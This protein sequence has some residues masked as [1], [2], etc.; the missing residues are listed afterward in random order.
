VKNILFLFLLFLG[1]EV[2]LAQ[3]NI[4]DSIQN[5]IE[6]SERDTNLVKIL[7]KN[8]RPYQASYP[9]IALSIA[10]L[11]LEISQE[12]GWNIGIGR[13]NMLIGRTYRIMGEYANALEA[14]L[15]AEQVLDEKEA[16]NE[17]TEVWNNIGVIYRILM[18]YPKALSY[19]NKALKLSREI[20]NYAVE[21]Y[22]L[23]SLGDVYK[24]NQEFKEALNYY[25]EAL[26]VSTTQE[27]I[28]G[29]AP[30]TK[31]VG[32][33]YFE[34]KNYQEAE[35]YFLK[36][37]EIYEE[38]PSDLGVA[39]SLINLAQLKEATQEFDKGIEYAEQ[40]LKIT[41]EVGSKERIY[42]ALDILKTLYGNVNNYEKAYFYQNLFLQ[43][44]DSLLANDESLEI[45]RLE[46][47][48]EIYRQEQTN[49][50]LK[51]NNEISQQT[52]FLQWLAMASGL[53]LALIWGF[54]SWYIYKK[55]KKIKEQGEELSQKNEELET[56]LSEINLKN[57]KLID[58]LNY[59]QRMQRALLPAK[60]EI[61]QI[62][63]E[64]FVFFSPKDLVSGDFYWAGVAA[65]HPVFEEIPFQNSTQKV[66]KY[67]QGEKKVF[68]VID[69]TGHGV[70]GG[71]MSMIAN[72]LLNQIVLEKGITAPDL[73]LREIHTKLK[74]LNRKSNDSEMKEGM[75]L[76]I[77]TIDTEEKKVELSAAF[78]QMIYFKN[79]E[80][81]HL[82]GNKIA[83]GNFE[84]EQFFTKT[85]IEIDEPITL[86]LFT[87]GY[88]D[89]FG[90]KRNRKFSPKRMRTLFQNIYQKPMEEQYY[91]IKAAFE[92]WKKTEEQTDDVLVTGL[93][94]TPYK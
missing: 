84:L 93:K 69:C 4:P 79:D 27:N 77:C 18:D 73:V 59:A 35:K 5:K 30:S 19:H 45:G 51:K 71:L 83:I 23:N 76:S 40:A 21:A 78:S 91:L 67:F 33:A 63:T 8:V 2:L 6:A 44:K 13:A 10:E 20:K 16:P 43:Y 81:V 25:Q 26:K 24:A 68:S 66:L 28:S 64:H 94:I 12:K 65:A 56:A 72:D 75:D 11:S 62:F 80:M 46:S 29:M 57:K 14:Y 92:E 17:L 87:D 52:I 85:T 49:E 70:P 90:G 61:Q 47:K 41:Q 42:Q 58:S 15:K 7:Q 50:I 60:E 1:T 32:V 9:E 48:F 22:I 86:Y 54:N 53:L 3:N 74:K 36:A 55:N 31:N 82:K 37:K 38:I 39:I 34:L 88:Q 89:Q